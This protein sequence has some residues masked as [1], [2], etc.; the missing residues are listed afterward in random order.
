MIANIRVM[1]ALYH[2]LTLWALGSDLVA[3]IF[4]TAGSFAVWYILRPKF[5]VVLVFF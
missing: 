1:T 5:G 3:P 2:P 4:N